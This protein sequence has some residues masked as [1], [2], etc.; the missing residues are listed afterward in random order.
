MDKV[1]K[2]K[3]LTRIVCEWNRKKITAE[4][5]MHKIWKLYEKENLETWNNPLEKLLVNPV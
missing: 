3:Q 4:E 1:Q 2:E 5:A